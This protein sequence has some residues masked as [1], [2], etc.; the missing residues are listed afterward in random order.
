MSLSVTSH[1]ERAGVFKVTPA[2]SIN[3]DTDSLLDDKLVEILARKP[4]V[5]IM[6]MAWVAYLASGGVRVILKAKK[7]L[8]K[9]DGVLIMM[10]LQPQIRK[11]FEIINALP[12]M[13]IFSSVQELD[14]Y[15][16]RMQ[17]KVLRGK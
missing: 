14:D 17:R 1:K 15:L 3:S 10:N 12:A 6:D 9:H 13:Q 16:D 5:I 7:Q 4:D 8:K 11:V 2:G